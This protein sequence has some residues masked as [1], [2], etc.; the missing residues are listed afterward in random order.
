MM[1]NSKNNI[2]Q[3]DPPSAHYNILQ[4]NIRR[5]IY[6]THIY[7]I[8]KNKINYLRK[9]R[10]TDCSGVNT[11]TKSTGERAQLKEFIKC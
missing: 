3:Y 9:Y 4:P 11:M 8:V 10:K 5:K 1:K 6:K 2:Q 7:K